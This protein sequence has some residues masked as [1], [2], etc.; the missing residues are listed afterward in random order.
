MFHLHMGWFKVPLAHRYFFK[1]ARARIDS[2]V[3][4]VVGDTVYGEFV[5]DRLV[6]DVNV[7]DIHVVHRAVVEEV[8]V[9]PISALVATAKVAKPVINAAVESDVR[10]PITC[11]PNISALA[12]SPITGGPQQSRLR[13]HHPCAWHPE[14]AFRTV[15]PITR[16]PD[17]TVT[18]TCRLDIDR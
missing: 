1:M 6:V 7:G 11:V 18:W 9:S 10:S 14:V 15:G 16:S 13:S 8:T 12:P 2:A 4:S 5:D 3:T 17:I